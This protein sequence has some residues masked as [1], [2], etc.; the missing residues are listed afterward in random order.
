MIE[1]RGEITFSKRFGF[2]EAGTDLQDMLHHTALHMEYIGRVSQL[3]QSL[4]QLA[5]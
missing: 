3:S 2:L 1:N 5:S 4:S